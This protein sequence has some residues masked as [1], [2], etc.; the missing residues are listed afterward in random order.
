MPASP[1][2][3][4]ADSL[5]LDCRS[6]SGG[7]LRGARFAGQDTRHCW[8]RAGLL[9]RRKTA[10]ARNWKW[11]VLGQGTHNW[12]QHRCCF[13]IPK[14]NYFRY[15]IVFMPTAN[16]VAV[17]DNIWSWWALMH[18]KLLLLAPSTDLKRRLPAIRAGSK[19]Q[20]SSLM[21][22]WASD[23]ATLSTISFRPKQGEHVP[24]TIKVSGMDGIGNVHVI[25]EAP[26]DDMAAR[27]GNGWKLATAGPK[28]ARK[29]ASKLAAC[30]PNRSVV[31]SVLDAL[32]AV[33]NLP[34]G[35]GDALMDG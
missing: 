22:R 20:S 27:P 11:S 33:A 17:G 23:Q 18:A 15:S 29:T 14:R 30:V 10:S 25:S 26:D 2:D 13:P 28:R 3:K 5:R 8:N 34:G 35:N 12:S 19:H 6:T 21:I 9:L 4:L 1:A 32:K 7:N 24:T 31:T 16:I